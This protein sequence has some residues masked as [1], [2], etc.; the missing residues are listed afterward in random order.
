MNI[1]YI[2]KII[3]KIYT[4]TKWNYYKNIISEIKKKNKFYLLKESTQL[5]CLKFYNE[6]KLNDNKL[7]WSFE[8]K[9]LEK[10]YYIR[11]LTLT[12]K[13]IILFINNLFIENKTPY[14]Y[15]KDIK[16][17]FLDLLYTQQQNN[18]I[19]YLHFW[20]D[21][22]IQSHFENMSVYQNL[23][24]TNIEVFRFYYYQNRNNFSSY[25]KNS[26]NDDNIKKSINN[27]T[28]FINFYKKIPL[29]IRE[30]IIIFSGMILQ[31][32]GTT[33]TNDIDILIVAPNESVKNDFL[34]YKNELNKN[35][36]YYILFNDNEWYNNKGLCSLHCKHILSKY[37]PE[38]SGAFDIS[39][40]IGNPEHHFYFFG[41][42]MISIDFTVNR[43][44]RRSTSTSYCDLLNLERINNYNIGKLCIPNYNYSKHATITPLFNMQNNIRIVIKKY[45]ND[46]FKINL[47]IDYLEKKIPNCF[48]NSL[49]VFKSKNIESNNSIIN[50][51]INIFYLIYKKIIASFNTYSA[52]KQIK[53][54]NIINISVGNTKISKYLSDKKNNVT[55]I[56]LID[57]I[58]KKNNLKLLE[59]YDVI[60]FFQGIENNF[61]SI[62]LKLQYIKSKYFIITK[63]NDQ[64]KLNDKNEAYY[65]YQNLTLIKFVYNNEYIFEYCEGIFG[66]QHGYTYK[67]YTDNEL[68]NLF[69][70]Q[71]YNCI[72]N[73]S[74]QDIYGKKNKFQ[75]ILKCYSLF[76][77]K[78][79]D[80]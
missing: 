30:K 76:I 67:Y 8:I 43:L 70:N 4:K 68:I 21:K 49:D 71:N 7:Y 79:E 53:S 33:Y 18:F 3:K 64:V 75:E 41:I 77:F 72:K 42:K 59:K 20:D 37:L 36:D 63:I 39:E 13:Q 46:W 74:F 31:S 32:L 58:N 55:D 29:N 26:N 62:F 15:Y 60:T 51:Y 40:I 78:K 11:K 48:N 44:K 9:P 57:L 80:L 25:F 12:K 27:F 69:K 23:L 73:I 19:I 17:N 66:L 24:L 50:S 65:Q 14:E 28:D 16:H 54:K 10:A 61:P 5:V 56:L 22:N 6:D 52:I 35:I 1:N 45:Y 47:S 38:K 34:K 2:Y